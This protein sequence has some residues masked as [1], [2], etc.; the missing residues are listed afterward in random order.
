MIKSIFNNLKRLRRNS[1]DAVLLS[2]F[3]DNR[4]LNPKETKY[5][6]S[7]YMELRKIL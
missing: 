2:L 1:N 5:E 4:R 3:Y 7:L 6:K